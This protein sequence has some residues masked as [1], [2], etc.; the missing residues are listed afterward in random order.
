MYLREERADRYETW[1]ERGKKYNK[2]LQLELNCVHGG[3]AV[4]VETNLEPR[5]VNL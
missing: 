2:V 5:Y 4:C 3:H 1:L